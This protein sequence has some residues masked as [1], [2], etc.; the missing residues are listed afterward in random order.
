MR[1]RISNRRLRDR[2]PRPL[3]MLAVALALALALGSL[4]AQAD[5]HAAVPRDWG[6]GM[7][8]VENCV[9]TLQYVQDDVTPATDCAIEQVFSR[10]ADSALQLVERHGKARFGEH[11]HIDRR[12]G[13]TAST[14]T[15][16]A[17]LDVILP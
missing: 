4:P 16:S 2:L 3:P 12:L 7:F 17:D 10:L 13:L 8:G 5:E 9:G 11:F 1:D 6:V 14:G 15:L